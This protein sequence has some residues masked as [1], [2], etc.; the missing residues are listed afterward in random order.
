MLKEESCQ[1][2]Y[3]ESEK[4]IWIHINYTNKA[5]MIIDYPSIVCVIDVMTHFLITFKKSLS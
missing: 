3:K 5:Q 1:Y 4:S 2:K